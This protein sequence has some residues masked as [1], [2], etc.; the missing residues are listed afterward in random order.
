MER[1]GFTMVT[2]WS[3]SCT[4]I[5]IQKWF[6]EFFSSI[7]TVLSSLPATFIFFSNRRVNFN[8]V[9]NVSQITLFYMDFGTLCTI[10]TPRPLS[11][12]FF[13]MFMMSFEIERRKVFAYSEWNKRHYENCIWLGW[14]YVILFVHLLVMIY[15]E[16][17][18][19][20]TTCL[21]YLLSRKYLWKNISVWKSN[22]LRY[23]MKRIGSH[24]IHS[25]SQTLVLTL[26]NCSMEASTIWSPEKSFWVKLPQDWL[27]FSSAPY[28]YISGY[29]GSFSKPDSAKVP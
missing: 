3:S 29:N 8:T 26:W 9:Y 11:F 12:I 20:I 28:W 17:P 4:V 18:C 21:K 19:N 13:C 27:D 23:I 6:F 22:I 5:Q 24:W 1:C 16:N 2:I 25:G 10:M 14:F 15:L 7:K